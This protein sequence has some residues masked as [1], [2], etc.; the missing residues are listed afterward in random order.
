MFDVE[1]DKHIAVYQKTAI[2]VKGISDL[3]KIEI[4]GTDEQLSKKDDQYI[5]KSKKLLSETL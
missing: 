5:I 3:A 1:K 4:L 2:L